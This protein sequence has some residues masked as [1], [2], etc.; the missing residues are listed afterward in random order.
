MNV[1]RMKGRWFVAVL[2]IAVV[3]ALAWYAWGP[4]HTPNGQ[5]PLR[6]LTND[7]ISAIKDSFNDAD[8]RVRIVLLLSPT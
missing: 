4:S 1:R 5:P 3:V 8:D 2:V 6:S 7:D